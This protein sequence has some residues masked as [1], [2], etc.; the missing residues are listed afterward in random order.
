MSL[1]LYRRHTS[2][3]SQS[4]SRH[5]RSY[6]SDELRRGF[7]KCQCPIQF[8]GKIKGTG[9]VRKSTEKTSWEE[10]KFVADSWEADIGTAPT[11]LPEPQAVTEPASVAKKDEPVTIERVA[12]EFMADVEA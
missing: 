3:C 4:R 8:E 12:S 7:K 9:F 2:R 6:E 5:E 1:T 10:A 11:Q